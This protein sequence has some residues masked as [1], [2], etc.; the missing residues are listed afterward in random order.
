MKQKIYGEYNER[1]RQYADKVRLD[2]NRPKKQKLLKANKPHIKKGKSS[3]ASEI[4]DIS[5]ILRCICNIKSIM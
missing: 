2:Q 5:S 4:L 3:L 1:R